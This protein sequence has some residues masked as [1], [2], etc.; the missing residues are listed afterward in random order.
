MAEEIVLL[1]PSENPFRLQVKYLAEQ[2][3]KLTYFI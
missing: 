3:H 1:D 2:L